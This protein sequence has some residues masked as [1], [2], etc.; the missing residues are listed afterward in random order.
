VS[1]TLVAA[2]TFVAAV[3]AFLGVYS[4]VV[5]LYLR[6]RTRLSQRLD[7]EFQTRSSSHGRR[8]PVFKN[9][10]KLARE[11]GKSEN[12]SI[13]HFRRWLAHMVEQSGLDVTPGRVLAISLGTALIAGA[14]AGL[15]GAWWLAP[16]AALVGA[17]AP[18]LYVVWKKQKR[19]EKLLSQMPDTFELVARLIRAGQT[20][21]QAFQGVADEFEPP[22]AAEFAYCYE[23]QNLGLA[24]ELALRD[25]GRR[26]D[27]VEMKIFILAVLVQ[28]QTGGNLAELIDNL[29]GIVRERFRI[30]GKIKVLTAEGRMEAAVLLALPP[31]V[32]LM[33]F[34][35][36]RSYAEV[37]LQHP[38]LIWT[39]V[40]FMLV[41][42]LWIRRIINFD[43]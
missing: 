39:M 23:Q 11:A 28:R 35:L 9:L 14:A 43:F 8:S 13:L 40:G 3:L 12:V 6:D 42:V 24:P 10:E 27:L 21:S 33:I 7:D 29:A 16:L 34:F 22:I 20:T 36:N 31:V 32:F 37:L 18:V 19:L 5:D 17:A 2:L 4:V 41:G 26:I 15:L 25:M 30:R 1:P 38:N